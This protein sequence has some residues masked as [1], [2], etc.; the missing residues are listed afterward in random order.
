MRCDCAAQESRLH[1]RHAVA[2]V[3]ITALTSHVTRGSNVQLAEGNAGDRW[4]RLK[5]DPM[6]KCLTGFGSFKN[7]FGPVFDR[8]LRTVEASGE[9]IVGTAGASF[10]GNMLGE[11]TGRTGGVITTPQV[12][13]QIGAGLHLQDAP[14]GATPFSLELPLKEGLAGI[15]VKAEFAADVNGV[16]WTGMS[17]T[18]GGGFHL[19]GASKIRPKLKVR[20]PVAG[21]PTVTNLATSCFFSKFRRR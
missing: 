19:A 1:H 4:F 10:K 18:L 5:C 17:I 15:G 21:V 13:A 11:G 14:L 3:R 7:A 8:I 9:I 6:P 12:S 2:R 16:K 20:R